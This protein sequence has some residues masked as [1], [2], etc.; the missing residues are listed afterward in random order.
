MDR[1]SLKNSAVFSMALAAL[2]LGGC[3]ATTAQLLHVI[4]GLK[5]KAEYPGL[6]NSR[7]AIVCVSDAS[8]YGPNKLTSTVSQALASIL[9]REVK[10]IEIVPHAEIEHWKDSNGWNEIDFVEIGKGLE[11]DKVVAIEIGSYSIHEGTTMYKGRATV[12]TTVYDIEQDGSIE[13]SQG[14]AE[15]QFPKSHGR[16]SL[17]TSEQQFEAV[18]LGKLVENISRSFYDSERVDAV[19]EDA[20]IYEF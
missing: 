7:V 8:S 16:P 14:P 20:T 10:N 17:S 18:Y 15:Y 3:I 11:A 12:K 5:V 1:R 13:F 2:L 6:K 19:A 4:H 9:A